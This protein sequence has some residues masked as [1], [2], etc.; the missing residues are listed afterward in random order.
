MSRREAERFAFTP[1]QQD[2]Y[3]TGLVQRMLQ[4]FGRLLGG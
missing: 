4:A 3:Q 2:D 1:E